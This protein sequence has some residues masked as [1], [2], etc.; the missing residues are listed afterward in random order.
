MHFTVDWGFFF[1]SS[2]TVSFMRADIIGF[3]PNRITGVPRREKELS[4]RALHY[5]FYSSR[6]RRAIYENVPIMTLIIRWS[7]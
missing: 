6:E 2:L 3:Y 4:Y 5:A 1:P 7:W